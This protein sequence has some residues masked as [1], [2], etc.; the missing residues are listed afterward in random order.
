MRAGLALLFAVASILG[1]LAA[2]AVVLAAEP[3][4]GQPTV[5][6][7][8]GQPLL[9]S[10][11]IGGDS[12]ASV[13]A[14]LHLQGNPTSIIAAAQQ[15]EPGGLWQ[16]QPAI[17]IASSAV[18]ACLAD[19][20]SAPNTHF[21]YHFRV[22]TTDGSVFDGPVAQAVVED[23]RYDWQVLEQDMVRVHWYAGDEA[24]AASAAAVA[25]DAIDQASQ[26]LGVTLPNEVDLFIYDT[27][28]AL[29]SAVSPNRENVAGEAHPDIS[30][31]FVHVPANS[32]ADSFAGPLIR[33][34]LTHLVFHEA[35]DNDYHGVPRWLDEGT[36]VYLSE[37]YTSSWQGVV[38][39]A[40][41]SADLIP[42]Q[43]LAGLFPSPYE[44]FRLAYGEAVAAVDYF[45]R[46]YGDQTFWDLVRSYSKGVSDDEAFSQATGGDVA[47]FN[48]AWFAS[49]GLTPPA[50]IGPQAGEPGPQPSDWVAEAQATPAPGA[51]P[52]PGASP[53]AAH[54]LPPTQAE[55]ATTDL[56]SVFLLVALIVAVVLIAFVVVGLLQRRREPPPTF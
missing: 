23:T 12:I 39:A 41:R 8:L 13:D 49:L 26:L 50:P 31:M 9:L 38:D 21:D 30:T 3:Q 1:V 56:T 47:A 45:I 44:Q 10:S 11:T 29:R 43:G 32:S 55:A 17:D 27:E 5:V 42:L 52:S 24:F 51:S 25:N 54:S 34:E 53:G 2:P 37:G 22:R 35:V 40:V 15:V 28:E 7:V 6:A 4:F 33:H 19:G 20:D 46:T 18:C 14:V 48:Q 16:A 36:A